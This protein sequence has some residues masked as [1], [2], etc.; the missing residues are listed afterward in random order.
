[1]W[2][3]VNWGGGDIDIDVNNNFNSNREVNRGDRATWRSRRSRRPGTATRGEGG[4]WQHNSANRDGTPYRDHASREQH[5]K[6]LGDAGNRNSFRGDDAQRAQARDQARQSMER[7]GMD[8]P[9]RDNSQAQDRARQANATGRRPAAYRQRGSN[10]TA[11]RDNA[12]R[13]SSQYGLAVAQRRVL[14]IA[15]SGRV[16][17]GVAARQFQSVHFPLRRWLARGRI[18]LRE[19]GRNAGWW[20]WRTSSMN[21]KRQISRSLTCFTL[22][23]VAIGSAFAAPALA[24]QA[25]PTPDAAAE[26]LVQAL[27]TAVPTMPSSPP[28]SARSGA[29]PCRRT[30]IAPMSMRSSRAIASFTASSRAPTGAAC[31]SSAATHGR[32]RSR[33]RRLRRLAIRRARGHGRNPRR[34]IG[35]NELDVL[36]AV[37]A[38]HDAQNDYAEV[39]RDGD[40]VL[41]YAQ[42][43]VSTDGQHDG[44]YWADDDSGEISPLGPLFGDDTPQADWLGYHYR[45]L[46]AQGTSAPRGAFDYML[47]DN[48]SPRLRTRRLARQV[49]RDGRDVVHHQPRRPRVRTRPRRGRRQRRPRDEGIR[50]G[51]R[52]EGSER[53]EPVAA[54][55]KRRWQV[56]HVVPAL[57][58]A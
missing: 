50:S 48:M 13:S 10:N 36:E 35:R 21:A 57:H 12:R 5:G 56:P 4:K 34:R 41:E 15:Q 1:M 58:L 30:S 19:P 46:R 32:S 24:Q 27:G 38:Y 26:A 29:T 51:Q 3:D 9:A 14:R 23:S 25:Y 18:A 39:D 53:R 40:G 52:L 49:R 17:I 45:I 6:Q 8:S 54:W 22:L 2:G 31:W 20:W 16:A 44:L 43:L 37:R 7:R 55:F 28:C 11:S 42:K 33:S 47:G